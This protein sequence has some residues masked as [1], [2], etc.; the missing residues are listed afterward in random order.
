MNFCDLLG[1]KCLLYPYLK[2]INLQIKKDGIF[3]EFI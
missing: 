1:K 3:K 2:P